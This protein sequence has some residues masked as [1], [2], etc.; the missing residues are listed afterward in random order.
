[1]NFSVKYSNYIE[2]GISE[3]DE[4]IDGRMVFK[5]F[6]EA[7]KKL[8]TIL[9]MEKTEINCRLREVRNFKKD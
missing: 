2:N 9:T 4:S 7:K 1:M 6:S 8:I 5:T 3:T